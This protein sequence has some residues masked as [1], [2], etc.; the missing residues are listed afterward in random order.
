M[1]VRQFSFDASLTEYQCIEE[2]RIQHQ[3]SASSFKVFC[4][5]IN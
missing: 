1:Q 4:S 5:N 3:D 2:L